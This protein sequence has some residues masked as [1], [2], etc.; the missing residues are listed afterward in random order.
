MSSILGLVG[1]PSTLGYTA[2]KHGVTGLTKAAAIAYSSQGVRVNSVHSGYIVTPLISQIDPDFLVRLYPI[3]RLRL[4]V[5][6]AMVT[7]FL[8]SDESSFV[9]GTQ[10]V[11]DGGYTAR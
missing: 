11:V 3:G 5:E 10:L 2:A 4:A 1:K 9:A 7:A 8:L 6:V